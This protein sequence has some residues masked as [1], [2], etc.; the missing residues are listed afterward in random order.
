MPVLYLTGA[1]PGAGKT[2][3]ASALARRIAATGAAVSQVRPLR[4]AGAG[5]EVDA[6]V[7]QPIAATPTA[8]ASDGALLQSA[9]D[10]V[11]AAQGA[12]ATIVEGLDGL[13][14]DDPVAAASARFA[15]D[16]E[17]R[18]VLLLEY[19]ETVGAPEAQAAVRRYGPRLLGAIV[20][21]V[22]RY[23]RRDAQA[24]LAAELDANG[25][26]VL[27]LM[28]EDRT[29]LA[30]SVAQVAEHLG[31][32]FRLLDR[33][34]EPGD[35]LEALVESFMVGGWP[36]D[37]G[38][39]VFSRRENKAAIIKGDRPD[40]QMAALE[41]STVCLVLTE[42][43]EPV[44]Y[45]TYQAEQ[46]QV[47]MMLVPSPT[48]EVMEALATVGRQATAHGPRKAERSAALLEQ[49]CDGDSLLAA[50]LGR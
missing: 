12:D 49:Y 28:P 48:L 6:P 29:M 46:R 33:L 8:L 15:D 34:D 9:R 44:Q 13:H 35:R 42:G 23:R 7:G 38:A 24:R 39:Y 5:A 20:N 16:L 17:A 36:L 18:V 50:A 47:P 27:G 14:D 3:V 32:E 25:V 45:I 19:G 41:T 2:A 1:A 21:R 22:P 43:R 30:P 4:V 37:N 31:A 26:R 10:M 40:L 11:A